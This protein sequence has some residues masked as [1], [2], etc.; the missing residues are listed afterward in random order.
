METQQL[1][2]TA[3]TF[4]GIVRV[5]LWVVC[6]F[7]YIQETLDLGAHIQLCAGLSH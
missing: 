7:S 6:L 4:L 3:L 1:N 2:T 5:D